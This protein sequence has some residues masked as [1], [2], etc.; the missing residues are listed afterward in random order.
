MEHLILRMISKQKRMYIV[1]QRE[2]SSEYLEAWTKR[3]NTGVKVRWYI[4]Y[5]DSDQNM[6]Y[7]DWYVGE[8]EADNQK[9]IEIAKIIYLE[10]T[11]KFYEGMQFG[12]ERL[13]LKEL[14]NEVKK[15]KMDEKKCTVGG[16]SEEIDKLISDKSEEIEKR[17]SLDFDLSKITEKQLE[18][19]AELYFGMSF[20]PD[21]FYQHLFGHFPPE[22]IVRTLGEG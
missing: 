5:A 12:F 3:R 15:I 4:S 17:K 1:Y 10:D 18:L 11:L 21:R 22:T 13:Y 19:A 6:S 9:F 14:K 7:D 8:F 16:I 2:M 20:C